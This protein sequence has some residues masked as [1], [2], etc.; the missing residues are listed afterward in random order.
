MA[1]KKTQS[2]ISSEFE[3][4][5]ACCKKTVCKEYKL[6]LDEHY[7]RNI[8][9]EHFFH[10]LNRHRV[11]P[12]VHTA[13]VDR[14]VQGVPVLVMDRLK[15]AQLELSKRNLQLTAELLRVAKA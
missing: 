6:N 8:N 14:N 3:L 13:L 15:H 11:L 4:V 9:W 1:T 5:L 2:R 10:L 7:F 12:H